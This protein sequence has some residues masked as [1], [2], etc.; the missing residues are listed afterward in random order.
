MTG[1]LNTASTLAVDRSEYRIFQLDRLGDKYRLQRLPYPLKILL[2]NLLCNANGVNVTEAHIEAMATW[3]PHAEPSTEIAF[4]PS[5]V[6]LQDFTGVPAIVDLAA[7]RDAVQALRGDP[8]RINPLA[9]A[10]LV[11]DHS[12]Q[13]DVYGKADTRDLN[14][15]IEYQRNRERYTFLRWGQ[16]A[17]ANFKAV[18][19]GTG[20][21]HQVNLEHLAREPEALSPIAGARILCLLGDSVTTD[22]I[23]PAAAI[24]ADSPAG[25]YLIER[26]WNPP[27]STPTARGAATT[28]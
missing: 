11:I 15:R 6:V 16:Q 19:P 13:V 22:H 24:M 26:G 20:I 23:S 28:R 2:E 27:N 1:A 17:F 8:R 5:R 4:V 25:R 12:V 3:D 14:T 21:V 18:P 7:M 10:E 9:P